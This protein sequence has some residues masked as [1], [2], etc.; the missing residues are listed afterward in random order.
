MFSFSYF[1]PVFQASQVQ[2]LWRRVHVLVPTHRPSYN[3]NG[4]VLCIFPRP[5]TCL[6]LGTLRT[7]SLYQNE[8]P[9]SGGYAGQ[10]VKIFPTFQSSHTQH[11]LSC[12]ICKAMGGGGSIWANQAM[13]LGI[14][15]DLLPL[16]QVSLPRP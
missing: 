10:I 6:E 1:H 15:V 14:I 9:V 8:R 3:T 12:I 5:A 13:S 11:M 7:S 16:T 2:G 4:V